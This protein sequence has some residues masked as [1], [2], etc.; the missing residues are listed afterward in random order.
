VGTR[1]ETRSAPPGEDPG[2]CAAARPGVMLRGA[3]HSISVEPNA[4]RF[5]A[6]GDPTRLRVVRQLV[7]G[8]RCVC[9]LRDRIGVSGSSLSHHLTVPRDAGLVAASRRGRWVDYTLDM[10]ALVGAFAA[11]TPEVAGAVR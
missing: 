10:E 2:P 1:D 6:Q 7:H 4:T 8:T 5:R 11:A 9:E 3:D